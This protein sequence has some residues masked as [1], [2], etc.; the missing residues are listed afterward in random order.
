MRRFDKS[1]IS[2]KLGERGREIRPKILHD[3]AINMMETTRILCRAILLEPPLLLIDL[4]CMYA[5]SW[6]C[7][8]RLV[9]V[10]LVNHR[11]SWGSVQLGLF[12]C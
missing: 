8:V 7:A 3:V 10:G 9:V 2:M 5:A 11:R 12:L 1:V 4:S 6:L